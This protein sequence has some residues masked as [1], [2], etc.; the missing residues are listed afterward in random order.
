MEQGRANAKFSG[1]HQLFAAND[2]NYLM[3]STE[4]ML[5]GEWG[6]RE[7][8]QPLSSSRL[9]VAAGRGFTV[10]DLGGGE[11]RL[12]CVVSIWHTFLVLLLGKQ[13]CCGCESSG[14]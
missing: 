13:N 4:T 6:E 12:R 5:G 3:G 2:N 11:Q 8:E 10:P 14:I 1:R 9:G 7:P